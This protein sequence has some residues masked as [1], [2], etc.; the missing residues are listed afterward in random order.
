M[1]IPV[2]ALDSSVR[3]GV[4]YLSEVQRADGGFTGGASP[5][6]TDFSNARHHPTVFFA[7]LMLSC[8]HGVVGSRR[9]QR[10]AAAFLLR[11]KS[12]AWSWN[13]WGRDSEDYR[14]RPYPDDLDGEGAAKLW[15]VRRF[16]LIFSPKFRNYLIFAC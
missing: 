8:L 9:V 2:Q 1:D 7:T 4:A 14:T 3:E 10:R 15:L 13:Y 6:P 11:H 12:P 16:Q 5:S